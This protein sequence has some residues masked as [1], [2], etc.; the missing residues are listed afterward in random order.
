[1]FTNRKHNTCLFFFSKHQV[2]LGDACV[3]L[4]TIIK[5][6]NDQTIIQYS[7]IP[8]V[9]NLTSLEIKSCLFDTESRP[10]RNAGDPKVRPPKSGRT[11]PIFSTTVFRN[12][13]DWYQ[14]NLISLPRHSLIFIIH[15]VNNAL[16]SMWKLCRPS[17]FLLL[18]VQQRNTCKAALSPQ[19]LGV[20]LPCITTFNDKP[21][22]LTS[23]QV[24]NTAARAAHCW[25]NI[26]F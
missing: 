22:N 20:L 1:M 5:N 24:S 4:E 3:P 8:A 14:T 7:D 10:M 23:Q 26:F 21:A 17:G 9:V 15:F 12:L 6:G 18:I 19:R 11:R 13:S 16:T 25:E 2:F